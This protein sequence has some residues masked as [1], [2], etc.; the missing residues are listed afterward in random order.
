MRLHPA[1]LC[2]ELLDPPSLLRHDRLE[3]GGLCGEP[4]PRDSERDDHRAGCKLP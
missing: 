2:L 3:I 4:G 1:L